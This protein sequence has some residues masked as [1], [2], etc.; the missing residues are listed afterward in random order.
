MAVKMQRST[1]E[2]II[3]G[4]RGEE[5]PTASPVI[6]FT[7]PAMI[8]KAAPPSKMSPWDIQ[9]AETECES[10]NSRSQSKYNSFRTEGHCSGS[11][12]SDLESQPQMC[13]QYL[14]QLDGPPAPSTPTNMPH[15]ATPHQQFL[16]FSTQ[17]Q[18][19]ASQFALACAAPETEPMQSA[20]RFSKSK[21][22]KNRPLVPGVQNTRP[23]GIQRPVVT[24]TMIQPYEHP[25][26]ALMDEELDEW[27]T[28]SMLSLASSARKDRRPR[29]TKQRRTMAKKLALI[30]LQNGTYKDLTA[31]KRMFD[32]ELSGDD[33][34]FQYTMQ[35]VTSMRRG[36]GQC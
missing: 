2:P 29:P 9:D 6:E 1:S 12:S 35:V 21:G 8:L 25:T 31:A 27:E 10:N 3:Q 28:S 15:P 19:Q 11:D 36:G 18:L 17:Q 14:D 4:A 5:L 33:M 34:L 22:I 23:V 26:A 24:K 16:G 13:V 20:N 32:A 30:M 7:A